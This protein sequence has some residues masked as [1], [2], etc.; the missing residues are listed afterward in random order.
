MSARYRLIH[1]DADPFLGRRFPVGAFVESASG[2]QFVEAPHL[3]DERCLGDAEEHRL[4]RLVL[5]SLR[6]A[7]SFDVRPP[8][9]NVYVGKSVDLPA[10][11]SNPRAWAEEMLAGGRRV[12]APVREEH[13]QKKAPQRTWHGRAFF[14]QYKVDQYVR[15]HF[16]PGA[17]SSGPFVEVRELESVS[18]YVLGASSLILIEP[19]VPTR[20]ELASDVR[21]VNTRFGAYQNELK[22]RAPSS[23][24]AW[25]V[26]LVALVFAGGGDERERAM[27]A[28]QHNA[29]VVDA[30]RWELA[31]SLVDEVR[32]VGASGAPDLFDSLSSGEP[33]RA[34]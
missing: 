34:D 21:D 16:K 17:V 2:V 8:A 11:V 1:F 29:R 27:L 23:E 19:I 3:P 7:R 9:P 32:I 31:R 10:S 22:Q 24:R 12:V 5:L 4:L 30:T 25:S 28:L 26:D 18:Q 13:A 33:S 6:A 14:K 20:K 15:D